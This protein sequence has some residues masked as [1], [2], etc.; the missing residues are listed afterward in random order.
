MGKIVY[1]TK[2]L[3]R[4]INSGVVLEHYPLHDDRRNQILESWDNNKYRLFW[5]FL[6]GR[7]HKESL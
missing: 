7:F 2:I 5:G 4:F 3:F 6:T 1:V